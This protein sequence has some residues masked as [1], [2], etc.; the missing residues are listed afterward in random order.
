MVVSSRS[1]L[2]IHSPLQRSDCIVTKVSLTFCLL[3]RFSPVLI[4]A[5]IHLEVTAFGHGSSTFVSKNNEGDNSFQRIAIGKLNVTKLVVNFLGS[6]AISFIASSDDKIGLRSTAPSDSCS[7]GTP[8]KAQSDFD[9][10]IVVDAHDTFSCLQSMFSRFLVVTERAAQLIIDLGRTY[11]LKALQDLTLF[12]SCIGPELQDAGDWLIGMVVNL[13]KI[14]LSYLSDMGLVLVKGVCCFFLGV[15]VVGDLW[16]NRARYVD[17]PTITLGVFVF[18]LL[19]TYDGKNQ[20]LSFA[21]IPDLFSIVNSGTSCFC[22]VSSL[23]CR[24]HSVGCV[25]PLG[26]DRCSILSR[27]SIVSIIVTSQYYCFKS[28]CTF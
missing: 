18:C 12:M 5:D 6:G 23:L 14:V 27:L 24:C 15:A 1:L 8:A 7:I 3:D 10:S 9:E 2:K 21:E 25:L 26:G 28:R 13:R 4:I 19:G 22:P 17:T 16:K 11:L 20:A